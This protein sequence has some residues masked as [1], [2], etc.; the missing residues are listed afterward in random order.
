MRDS[1]EPVQ[2]GKYK[3]TP[4]VI[5]EAGKIQG[6][7]RDIAD[8]TTEEEEAKNANHRKNKGTTGRSNK[9]EVP[10]VDS[11]N[12]EGKTKRRKSCGPENFGSN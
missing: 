12:P 2:L 5:A 3:G 11:R 4:I 9:K 10:A 6:A 8:E 1:G 7:E